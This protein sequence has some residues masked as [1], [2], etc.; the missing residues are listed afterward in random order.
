[1]PPR[2]D[3]TADRCS[4]AP[5]WAADETPVTTGERR[6]SAVLAGH[7]GDPATAR[8]LLDDADGG[9]RERALGALARTGTLDDGLL[10]RTARDPDVRVRRRTAEVIG[11]GVGGTSP[12]ARLLEDADASVVEVAAWACGERPAMAALADRVAALATGHD[13]PLVREAAVAALG[14][15]GDPRFL[16]AVLAATGDKA[17]VRRRAVI[18]LAVFEGP[19]VDAALGDGPGRPGLAGPPGGRGSRT[20]E[21]GGRLVEGRRVVGPRGAVAGRAVRAAAA[22]AGPEDR[23]GRRGGGRRSRPA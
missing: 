17:T 7:L 2:V 4:T 1:M 3:V 22:G 12:L 6:R 11:A 13:D 16:P 20:D 15:I 23:A 8:R 9:V 19:E 10:E 14:A 21:R 5:P 18:A